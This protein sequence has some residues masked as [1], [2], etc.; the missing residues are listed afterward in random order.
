MERTVRAGAMDS[1]N[2]ALKETGKGDR[3][4]LTRKAAEGMACLTFLFLCVS[5]LLL[6]RALLNILRLL[7]C[8]CWYDHLDELK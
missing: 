6:T 4:A 5:V 2:I 7:F 1:D 3:V 8:C